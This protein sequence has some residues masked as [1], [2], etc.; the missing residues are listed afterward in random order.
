MKNE[1]FNEKSE[2]EPTLDEQVSLARELD[3]ANQR[4]NRVFEQYPDFDDLV[5]F[6]DGSPDNRKLLE[7]LEREAAEA[8]DKF[9]KGVIDKKA[10]AKHLRD[11]GENRLAEMITSMF[12]L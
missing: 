12:G 9:D 11:I 3:D 8:R 6:A 10:L 4:R 2:K 5:V 7:D 1:K